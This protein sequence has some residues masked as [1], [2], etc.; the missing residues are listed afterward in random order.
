VGIQFDKQQILDLLIQQ[1]KEHLVPQAQQKL[2]AKVDHQQ[3]AS[4]LQE[5]GIDPK[6]LGSGL[7]GGKGLNL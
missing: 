6:S 2:P 1:G 7:L 3:H 5:L 4:M